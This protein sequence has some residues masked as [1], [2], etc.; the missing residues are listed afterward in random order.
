MLILRRL[1]TMLRTKTNCQPR[2]L[3]QQS[4][5]LARAT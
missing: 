5:S 2:A 3:I 4:L 1:M